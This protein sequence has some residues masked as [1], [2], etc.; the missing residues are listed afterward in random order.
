MP[1]LNSH[2]TIHR[3]EL[4]VNLG[5]RHKER[6]HEQAVLLDVDIVFSTPPTACKTDQLE[7]SICYAAL[8]KD[9]RD[10]VSEKKYRLIEHL[11]CD[12]YHLIKVRMPAKAKVKVCITKYPKIAGLTDGVSFH[13][14][15]T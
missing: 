4:H 13:Y 10:N 7:D 15:D 9:I 3:L 12:I 14:G 11:S 8:I 1:K 2:L 5:W 6:Q